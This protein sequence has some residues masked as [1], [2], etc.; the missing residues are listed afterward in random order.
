MQSFEQYMMDNYTTEELQDIAIHGCQ[1]GV[2]GM[3]YYTETTALYEQFQD[4]LHEIVDTYMTDTGAQPDYI[5]KH[6]GN[7]MQFKNAMVWF[8]A[9]LLAQNLTYEF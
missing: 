2:S 5:Y 9:E 3:I 7:N 4:D 8:C 1:G 6:I